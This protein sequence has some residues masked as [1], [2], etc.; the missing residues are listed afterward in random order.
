[1]HQA[2]HDG[3]LSMLMLISLNF[4]YG[5]IEH[6]I[7]TLYILYNLHVVLHHVHTYIR[8]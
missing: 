4:K 3:R 8:T 5:I 1:M 2:E 6:K 7:V